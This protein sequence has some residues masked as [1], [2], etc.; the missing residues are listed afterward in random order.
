MKKFSFLFTS[1]LLLFCA[2]VLLTF[3]ITQ[4]L[5]QYNAKKTELAET[6]NFKERLINVWEWIP[7]NTVGDEKVATWQ[8]LQEE[9]TV[10]YDQALLLGLALGGIVLL[11]AVANLFHYR[12]QQHKLQVYG[13]V[14]VFASLS[15]L[16]LGLQSPFL[17]V[18][19]YNKDLA[20]QIPIDVDLDAQRVVKALKMVTD[21][22]DLVLGHFEYK[23]DQTFKGRM[24]YFYQ[25]KSILDLIKLLYTGGNFLVALCLL[26]FS[27][28]FPITKLLT[29]MIV[30]MKPQTGFARRAVPVINSL[31]K[32]SMADVFV[33]AVFLAYFSFANMNVGVETGATTLIGTYFFLAFVVLSILSG[34][35]FKR[36]TAKN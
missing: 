18:E 11:F 28:V 27:I 31:G 10:L 15:F 36:L 29:S 33:A 24:Y 34:T 2:V 21:Q 7:Y 5:S 8:R 13:L 30:F 17:E 25:N 35:F 1:F 19:A 12:K 20:F 14:M 6:L 3:G 16:Y 9:A 4:K 32:W 22:E 26:F 23:I